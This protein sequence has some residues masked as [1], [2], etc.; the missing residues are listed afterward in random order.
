M[1]KLLFISTVDWVA[2]GG[3][4]E[5]L[6]KTALVLRKMGFDV[7]VSVRHW[8]PVPNHIAQLKEA[9]CNI[10]YRYL[11]P[12]RDSLLKGVYNRIFKIKKD[13]YELLDQIKPD[14]VL[15][16]QGDISFGLDWGVAAYKKNI[17]YTLIVQLVNELYVWHDPFIKIIVELHERSEAAY[18]VSEQNIE[19][20][21]SIT[22]SKHTKA[23]IIRNPFKEVGAVTYPFVKDTFNIAF[24]ASLHSYHKG[25]DLLFQVLKAEKWKSRNLKINLYGK[26]PNEESLGNLKELY[27][28]VNINFA[29]FE[30]DINK[31]YSENHAF[32][33]CSR[34]EGQSLAL[35]EA[36][37]C[38]RV[39]IV[40]NVG[41]AR[42]LI[43]D[44]VDG[45]IAK[46]A[47]VYEIEENLERAWSK[48]NE[49]E[50]MGKRAA[51]KIR[52]VLKGNPID[53]FAQNIKDLLD[54]K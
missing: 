45:F 7:H 18:F 49:W 43:E 12:K 19:L 21:E 3:S 10:H 39:P 47:S 6:F 2:W 13:P 16:N 32:L 27:Q 50:E 40:T 23:K 36:M 28:L 51:E 44:G 33:L 17:K 38:G 4:E 48:R 8:D 29:G 31:V 14:L 37:Y 30:K 5:L 35:I 25:H 42:E 24:V 11:P 53:L 20:Y 22:G 15:I 54:N 46:S 9:G 41:G 52:D 34:M 26:G 1:K